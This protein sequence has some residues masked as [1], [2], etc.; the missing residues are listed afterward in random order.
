MSRPLL[1][2]VSLSVLAWPLSAEAI[3]MR[4]PHDPVACTMEAKI[5]PDGSSVSRTGPNCEFAPCPGEPGYTPPPVRPLP[6]PVPP[7]DGEGPGG[8]GGVSPGSPGETVPGSSGSGESGSV[9]G[10]VGIAPS[11]VISSPGVVSPDEPVSG[12]QTGLPD[13]P[14]LPPSQ[15]QSVKFVMEHRSSLDGQHVTVHGIVTYALPPA[16][17]CPPGQGA[18]AQPRI[19]IADT[20]DSSRNKAYDLTILLPE[21]DKTDYAEGQIVDI[22]GTVSGSADGVTVMKE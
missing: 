15:V 17:A 16:K 9:E 3:V 22:S 6:R 5:C 12:P 2:A 21:D 14:L 19:I 8:T 13:D 1:L 20:A 4:Q 7:G 11:G 10:G 18:C